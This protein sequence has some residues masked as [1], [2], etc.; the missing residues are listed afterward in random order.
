MNP[1]GRVGYDAMKLWF[2]VGL[3]QEQLP[4]I[5]RGPGLSLHRFWDV[6]TTEAV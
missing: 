4:S 3:I 6:E 1:L 2:D 5:E